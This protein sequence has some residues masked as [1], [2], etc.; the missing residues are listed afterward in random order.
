LLLRKRF[1]SLLFFFE[2]PF[3]KKVDTGYL[4]AFYASDYSA[5]SAIAVLLTLITFGVAAYVVSRMAKSG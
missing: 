2:K 4:Q 5:A 3:Q 1:H